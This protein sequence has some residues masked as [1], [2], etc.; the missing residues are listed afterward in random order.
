MSWIELLPASITTRY[1]VHNYNHAVEVLTS[2]RI[3]QWEEITSALE[4]FYITIADIQMKGGNETSIPKRLSSILRLNGWEETQL[5]GDLLLTTRIRNSPVRKKHTIENFVG[6][7][8]I[9]YVKN[10][11][12][13]DMEWNSKDQT[14][15]R[16]LYAFRAFQQYGLI[17]V[18]I[19]ITRSSELNEI[20]K[21][22]GNFKDGKSV[23]GKYGASTTWMGKLTPRL[24]RGAHGGCPVLVLGITP[25]TIK[26][27]N[28][29]R[30]AYNTRSGRRHTMSEEKKKIFV[31]RF[32]TFCP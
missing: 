22:M 12:A 7:Y 9:D 3:Q 4:Q 20:F 11:I 1:E 16:D 31:E 28:I 26:R 5:T 17:D 29:S 25:R 21:K 10:N 6:T 18:G 2:A 24:R 15:D 14:F 32:P 13:I 27:L 30:E 8:N 23:M 19:I